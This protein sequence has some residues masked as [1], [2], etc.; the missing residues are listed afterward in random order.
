MIILDI[1]IGGFLPPQQRE[2]L[3]K[4][5]NFSWWI[6]Q[7][8]QFKLNFFYQQEPHLSSTLILA[9]IL[10]KSEFGEHPLSQPLCP[11]KSSKFSNNLTLLETD[12]TWAGKTIKYLDKEYKA[13]E[14]WEEFGTCLSDL[15]AFRKG[16]FLNRY[17]MSNLPTT[18]YNEL[19]K[20]YRLEDFELAKGQG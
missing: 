19:I 8:A 6:T 20:N 11:P 3:V 1:G 4:S 17:L 12:T 15:I 14:S 9:E 13:F 5:I 16:G 10:A 7:Q 18:E 2:F